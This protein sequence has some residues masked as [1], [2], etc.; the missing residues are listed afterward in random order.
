[1]RSR[2]SE[3]CRPRSTITQEPVAALGVEVEP[4]VAGLLSAPFD[5]SPSFLVSLLL[6]PLP[7]DLGA[8]GEPYK[9]AYHPPPFRMNPAPPDTCRLAASALQLGQCRSGAS[10]I[11][12]SASQP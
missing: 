9:S 5:S 10:L 2:N 4:E 11:D 1:M 12:C 7:P 3:T 6:S 8:F